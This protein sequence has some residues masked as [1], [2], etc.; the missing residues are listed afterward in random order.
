MENNL[1]NTQR[2]F[3]SKYDAVHKYLSEGAYPQGL[4]G[5]ERNTLRRLCQRFAVHGKPVKCIQK[6]MYYLGMGINENRFTVV[7]L[8]GILSQ[9]INSAIDASAVAHARRCHCTQTCFV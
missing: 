5:V 6:V 8:L 4:N 2:T 3:F 7:R 9:S 1:E